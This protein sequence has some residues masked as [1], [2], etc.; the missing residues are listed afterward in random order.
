M[1][2]LN[3]FLATI[4]CISAVVGAF[5]AARRFMRWACPLSVEP[6]YTMTF[7]PGERDQVHARVVNGSDNVLYITGCCARG[8]FSRRFILRRHMGH[9]LCPPRL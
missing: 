7:E 6:S 4:G 3:V 1:V 5:F 2:Y 9:L 8:T